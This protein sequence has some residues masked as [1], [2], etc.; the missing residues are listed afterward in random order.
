MLLHSFALSVATLQPLPTHLPTGNRYLCSRSLSVAPH[1]L[2]E[3]KVRIQ[4]FSYGCS[5]TGSFSMG[6][7]ARRVCCGDILD[8]L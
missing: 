2:R 6:V 7:S 8:T 3:T 1:G 4:E 5:S